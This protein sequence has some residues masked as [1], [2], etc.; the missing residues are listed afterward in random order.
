MSESCPPT[1]TLADPLLGGL[2]PA[3]GGSSHHPAG[4]PPKLVPD[5]VRDIHLS[6]AYRPRGVRN[7]RQGRR[8]RLGALV[9]V[10]RMPTFFSVGVVVTLA[11]VVAGLLSKLLGISFW[12]I[13]VTAFVASILAW[14]WFQ[15]TRMLP[16]VPPGVHYAI[17]NEV[18]EAYRLRLTA[19]PRQAHAVLGTPLS[20]ELFEPRVFP[21]PLALPTPAWP[22][23]TAY[24]VLTIL[25]SLAWT[26]I[27]IKVMGGFNR[28]IGGPW[29]FWAVMSLAMIPFAW[30]W[31]TYLR[32]SPGRLEVMR[33]RFLGVGTPAITVIDLRTARV[34]ID[35][36]AGFIKIGDDAAA[37][38]IVLPNY[39]PRWTD[40]ARAV[41][42]SARHEGDFVE[43]LPKD[44]LVG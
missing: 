10:L 17:A 9:P 18:D 8:E 35:L 13:V 34:L 40:I 11:S 20:G 42:E 2:R 32:I 19:N 43:G 23:F 26:F 21:I 36:G 4:P 41:L 1:S 3:S 25:A 31:P 29:D 12:P 37:R 16:K 30:T 15:K 33:Y 6:K 24:I 38:Q 39:G 14:L 28:F 7:R 22:A 27:R 44:A 5:L